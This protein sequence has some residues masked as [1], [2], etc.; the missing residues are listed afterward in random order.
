[1]AGGSY[2]GREYTS[3]V[4]SLLPGATAWVE[5]RSLPRALYVPRASVVGGKMRL[6]GGRTKT[7]DPDDYRGY[8]DEVTIT[9]NIRHFL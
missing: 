6:V 7:E 2:G 5:K 4:A 8:R 3:S 1:M 9:S